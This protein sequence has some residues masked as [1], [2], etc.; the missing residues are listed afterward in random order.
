MSRAK[1]VYETHVKYLTPDQQLEL[2]T[3]ISLNLP[4]PSPGETKFDDKQQE[5]PITARAAQRLADRVVFG[6]L[7]GCALSS[8]E[9]TWA[10]K[11]QPHWRV[12]YRLF[13]GTLVR[14]VDV[15]AYTAEVYLTPRERDHLLRQLERVVTSSNAPA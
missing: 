6:D 3:M 13:D 14:V 11:P 8:G 2:A 7:V 15:D 12:P 10:P 5:R 1:E 4:I 9:P